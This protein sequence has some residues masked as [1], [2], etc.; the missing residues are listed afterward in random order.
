VYCKLLT[1]MKEMM[2]RQP[3]C[4]FNEAAILNVP[5]SLCSVSTN[6]GK[7]EISIIDT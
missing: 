2:K 4:F 6:Q 3:D 7:V 1:F 5:I